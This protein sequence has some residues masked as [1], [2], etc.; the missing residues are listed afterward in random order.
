MEE[1]LQQAGIT[2]ITGATIATVSNS[3]TV[4][5]N[6]PTAHDWEPAATGHWPA[7]TCARLASLI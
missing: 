7:T 6:S 1:T 5:P 3:R 2:V 4:P